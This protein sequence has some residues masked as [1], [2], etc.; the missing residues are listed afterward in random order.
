MR[1]EEPLDKRVKVEEEKLHGNKIR[2]RIIYIR[3][4]RNGTETYDVFRRFSSLVY[5]MMH[6]IFPLRLPL[7]KE[8]RIE[9][10][11]TAASGSRRIARVRWTLTG[12]VYCLDLSRHKV[13]VVYNG[14]LIFSFIAM[15]FYFYVIYI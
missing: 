6:V 5:I 12:N 15:L 14:G 1:L 7:T 13:D 11:L 10:V 8:K 9:I 2:R 3:N 4:K